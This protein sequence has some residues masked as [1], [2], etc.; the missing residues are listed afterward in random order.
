MTRQHSNTE[1]D[2]STLNT[3]DAATRPLIGVSTYLETKASWGVWELPAALLPAGYPRLV[4]AAGG[5]AS[6]VPPD[7]PRYAA[8][9]VARLGTRAPLRR[10]PPNGLLRPRHRH[11]KA[12]SALWRWIFTSSFPTISCCAARSGCIKSP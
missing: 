1:S 3:K 12:F 4:Q 5:L 2:L 11:P 7:D 6:M 9:V 10:A 8:D